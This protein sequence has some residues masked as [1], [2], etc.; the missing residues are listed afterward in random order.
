MLALAN[1]IV[2]NAFANEG[3]RETLMKRAAFFA[4]C[5]IPTVAAWAIAPS[6]LPQPLPPL[7]MPAAARQSPVLNARAMPARFDFAS[8]RQQAP[9]RIQPQRPGSIQAL[10]TPV[11]TYR[12]TNDTNQDIEPAIITGSFSG[13]TRT[14]VAFTKYINTSNPVNYWTTTTDFVNFGGAPTGWQ[15]PLPSGTTRSSDPMLSENPYSNA[16]FPNRTYCSGVAANADLSYTAVV[17][18]YSDYPAG[19]FAW[20]P[21]VLAAGNGVSYDKP[22]IATSW[23][24]GS[25]GYTYV[26]AMARVSGTTKIQLYRQ[27][28]TLGFTAVGHIDN[29]PTGATSPIVVVDSDS[30]NSGDVYVLW[31]DASNQVIQIA[32]S[33]DM[34]NTFGTPVSTPTT[35]AMS[36]PGASI[37]NW[38]NP[39]NCARGES[40]IMAKLN[41]ADRSIGVVWHLHETDNSHTDVGFN[42]FLLTSR[43][44]LPALSWRWWRGVQVGHP[45]ANDGRD[46]W[47]PALAP[48]SDG[49]YM[50]TWYD[51]RNDP[52]GNAYQVFAVRTLAD[53]T[54]IDGADTLIYNASAA[55][56][57]TLLPQLS[58]PGNPTQAYMGEYQ[59][60]WE[61]YGT[62]YGATTYIDSSG[63]Q[64]IYIMKI[65]Q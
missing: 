9:A 46:Q 12:A 60:V 59:D 36:G 6:P 31:I 11:G 29:L 3:V 63:Q 7:R 1:I 49:S 58:I 54:P 50:M 40:V 51:K 5:L 23:N 39:N 61:W 14:T 47:N 33:T 10:A 44:G 19:E 37:C 65:T 48:S 8:A 24:P 20:T 43:V 25:R 38:A 21:L 32:R 41:P 64:D 62:W 52:A 30:S 57:I 56:N 17:V 18:W 16:P 13:S 27:T 42:S 2:M 34:G 53:G 55:A 45:G 22:S 35:A 15:L 28:T 26:A 4:L